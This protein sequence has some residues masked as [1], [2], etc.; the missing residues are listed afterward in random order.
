MDNIKRLI[1]TDQYGSAQSASIELLDD[2]LAGLRYYQTYDWLFLRSVISAG[3]AG[4]IVYSLIF[5]AREYSNVASAV[6]K[7]AGSLDLFVNGGAALVSAGLSLLLVYKE[8]PIQFFAYI[9]FPIYFWWYTISQRIFL[10]EVFSS[11][12]RDPQWMTGLAYSLAYIASLE[13][14]VY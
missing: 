2:C 5:I 8:S 3:Y 4:W 11:I 12:R 13:V 9:A 7:E 6:N 1:E 10:L 14:L